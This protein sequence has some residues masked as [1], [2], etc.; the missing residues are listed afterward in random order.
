[1]THPAIQAALL[2]SGVTPEAW[3]QMQETYKRNTA[4]VN[5]L[6]NEIRRENERKQLARDMGEA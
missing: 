3:A 2:L 5:R 4:L 6:A 1:M